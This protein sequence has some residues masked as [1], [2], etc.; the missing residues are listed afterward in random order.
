M[1]ENRRTLA[2]APPPGPEGARLILAALNR[3]DYI[4]RVVDEAPPLTAEQ[5]GRLAA[6]LNE[7]RPVPPSALEVAAG[8]ELL[9]QIEGEQ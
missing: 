6:V 3:Q 5:R 7:R 2:D 1:S 9:G 8:D 4:R